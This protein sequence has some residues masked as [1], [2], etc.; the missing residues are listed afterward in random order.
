LVFAIALAVFALLFALFAFYRLAIIA[1]LTY[2]FA[3]RLVSGLATWGRLRVDRRLR[4]R[5]LT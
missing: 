4:G 2:V 5:L 3:L 1:R